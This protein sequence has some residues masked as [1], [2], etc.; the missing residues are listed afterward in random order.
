MFK[1][2]EIKYAGEN[3]WKGIKLNT[4]SATAVALQICLV[5]M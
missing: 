2:A 3:E 1:E 5:K 4:S